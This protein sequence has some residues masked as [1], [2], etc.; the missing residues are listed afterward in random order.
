MA[1]GSVFGK[2]LIGFRRCMLD[3]AQ[4]PGK[5]QPREFPAQYLSK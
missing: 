2:N 1:T 5:S 4:N 3:K